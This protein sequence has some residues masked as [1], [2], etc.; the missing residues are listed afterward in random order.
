[1]IGT[2]RT[3]KSNYHTILTTTA[4]RIII[5]TVVEGRFNYNTNVLDSELCGWV[6]TLDTTLCDTVCQW[7]ATGRYFNPGTLVSSTYE[8][9][10]HNIIEILLKVALNSITTVI[11]KLE[12]KSICGLRIAFRCKEPLHCSRG[13]VFRLMMWWLWSLTPLST[14]FQLYCGGK[15]HRSRKPEY[16]D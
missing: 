8:T 9:C 12:W 3:R 5:I 14:I 10:L 7:L 15:F 1:V 2:D 13:D 6:T 16:P 4:V 11:C